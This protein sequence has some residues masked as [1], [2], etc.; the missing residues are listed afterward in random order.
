MSYNSL[1]QQQ[2]YAAY[3]LA[4]QT[5]ENKTQQIVMLYDGMMQH[6]HRARKAILEQRIEER[7]KILEKVSQII[8]GLQAS[9]DF[10]QGGEISMILDRYYDIIFSKIHTINR[11]NSVESCDALLEELKAMRSAWQSVHEE[12]TVKASQ[13]KN[14]TSAHPSDSNNNLQVSV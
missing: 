8:T 13:Q 5:T 2:Q 14:S 3:T 4:H 11:E 12:T 6:I 7:Y 1:H 9:L 10:E